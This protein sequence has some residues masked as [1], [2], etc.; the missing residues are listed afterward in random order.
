MTTPEIALE[1]PPA[2]QRSMGGFGAL[3]ITLSGL[4]PTIGV[5]IVG[6]DI[7]KQAG[8]GVVICF[9]AAAVLG[10]AMAAV[11]AELASAFPET[12]GEYTIAGRTLGPTAGF[13]TLGLTLS[14][15]TIGQALS[16]LGVAGYLSVVAPDLPAVPT[17]L[18]LVVAATLIAILNLKVSAAVTGAFLALEAISLVVLTLL[19]F[20]HPHRTVAAAILHP[21]ALGSSGL[22]IPTTIAL[23]GVA[24]AGAIYAFNGYGSA[25]ALGEEMHEAPKRMAGVIY[26]ALGLAALL[27]I[28]PMVAVSVGAVDLKALFASPAPLPFFI[29]QA[30]GPW[31]GAAMSLGVA[32]A[33][34]NA[35]IAIALF[36][37]R[38]L[39]ATARDGVWTPRI[40]AALT[41]IHPRWRSPWIATLV[42]GAISLLWCFA[43]MPILITVIASGT[44][45]IYVSLCL[46]VM[47]G[48]R[49]GT[50]SH[51][52]YRMP[53][54]PLAPVA[55]LSA[56]VAVLWTSLMDAE[57]GRPGVLASLMIV[58]VSA[59]L[60]R[61]VLRRSG[62]WS[63][64]GPTG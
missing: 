52:A 38:L 49:R 46:A 5:F 54:Y 20:A 25:V 48:R 51:G 33:I 62:R 37:G 23:V 13:A 10:V 14:G 6:S 36:A 47:M 45:G 41:H 56:M 2:L 4:S 24:S 43:P 28:A 16:A 11:Y 40:D 35:M 57:V 31:L 60:Y 55:A 27:Q 12:G 39:F 29:A 18:V 8:T 59:G 32:V 30:G 9:A 19:G 64:R 44:V 63:H 1:A 58:A 61:F 22:L 53:L 42:M 17:A 21:T 34:F 15:F 50:T 26:K 7:F 3:M